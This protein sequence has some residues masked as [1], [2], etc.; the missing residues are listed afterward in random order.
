MTEQRTVKALP[1]PQRLVGVIASLPD[2]QS[3]ARLRRPPDLFELRLD[4][5]HPLTAPAERLIARL[6]QPLIITARH[7]REGG[8]NNLSAAQRRQ[9]LQ[10]FLPKAAFVDVELRAEGQMRNV[11]GAAAEKQIQRI[12]SVHD[13]QGTPPLPDLERF[14]RRAET[15]TPDIFKLVT[16]TDRAIDLE[17]LLQFFDAHRTRLRLSVMGLGRL[18]LESRRALW[19]RGSALHYVHLGHE[20]VPGQFPLSAARR[21]PRARLNLAEAP[22]SPRQIPTYL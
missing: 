7:P 2:L 6:T 11:L 21:L 9:L 8:R 19:R 16:R 17:R 4:A 14:L 15:L 3:A 20:V 22:P 1:S 13:L 5:L 10:R 12:L 18:G